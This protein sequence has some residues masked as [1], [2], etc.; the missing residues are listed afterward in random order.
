[1]GKQLGNR[2]VRDRGVYVLD[3]V[4]DAVVETELVLFA[5]FQDP[6]RRKALGMGGH[7]EAVARREGGALHE[8]RVT[9][10]LFEN[11]PALVRD[12]Y[13]AARLF[14]LAHL[15]LYPL[16]DVVE[17]CLQPLAHDRMFPLTFA[18]PNFH[19]TAIS[20]G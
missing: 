4:A 14:V 5:E 20:P 10:R 6:R 1:M 11:N 13:H 2:H 8:V 15:E 3:I 16:R 17:G 19:S 12:R 18:G 9:K 7:T